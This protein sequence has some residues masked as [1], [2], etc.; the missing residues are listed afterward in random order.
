MRIFCQFS[1]VRRWSIV[2][3]NLFLMVALLTGCGSASQPWWYLATDT[4][5]LFSL[6]WS[7]QQH[8]A[9]QLVLVQYPMP[10]Q[11]DSATPQTTTAPYRG[12][13]S[14]N[15]Q[16]VLSVQMV[17]TSWTLIGQ[18]SGNSLVL[19]LPMANGQ[20]TPEQLVPVTTIQREQLL[21]AFNAYEQ[22]R[23]TLARLSWTISTLGVTRQNVHSL[24]DNGTLLNQAPMTVKQTQNALHTIQLA[25]NEMVRCRQIASFW[26]TTGSG[27]D[28]TRLNL[29]TP[30][31]ATPSLPQH[32]ILTETAAAQKAWKQAQ[33]IT[34]P[35][36]DGLPHP[37]PWL[38]TAV[39]FQTIMIQPEQLAQM[40]QTD[41]QRDQ[42]Q[43]ASF[44]V[45]ESGFLKEIQMTGQ[46]CP[47]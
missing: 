5:S 25:H 46:R 12:T 47:S 41:L 27:M 14:A 7:G 36:I 28:G 43:L 26:R 34:V 31:Q 33:S 9:G 44:N 18:L 8:I 32:E 2:H 10:L 37:L 1:M 38:V 20:L 24:D 22:V 42:Q 19:A 11:N 40:I 29:A 23:I 16:V 6:T 39:Q 3:L 45:Q 4:T 17:S 30:F 21:H 35:Q 13:R 15:G